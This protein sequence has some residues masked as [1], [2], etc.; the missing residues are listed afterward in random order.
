MENKLFGRWN[1][2]LGVTLN[3]LLRTSK[4][5][6]REDIRKYAAKHIDQCVNMYEYS[7]FDRDK[8]GYQSLNQQLVELDS[9]DDCGAFGAAIL[10]LYS[11]TQDRAYLPLLKI[12]ADYIENEQIRRDGAFYRGDDT[13]WADDLYMSTPFLAGY[14]KLTGDLTYIDDAAKQFL[15][16]KSISTCRNFKLCPMCTISNMR[17]QR[18]CRGVVETGGCCSPC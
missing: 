7:L 14:Y 17:H 1:Y 10:E 5:L 9:L 6:G 3:G 11:Q 4:L 15:C 12:I 13:M 16:S 2:H 18:M 8:Y